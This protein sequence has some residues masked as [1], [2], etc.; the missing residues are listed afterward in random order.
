[1]KL[2]IGLGNPGVK[3]KNTRHNLGFL[4]LDYLAQE[5]QTKFTLIKNFKAEIAEFHKNNQKF[6]LVKPLTYMNLSGTTVKKIKNF[7]KITTNNIL[8]ISDDKDMIFGKTR[9]RT[10]GRS[11]G[12]NGLKNIITEIASEEFLRLKVGVGNSENPLFKNSTAF[13]LDSFSEDELITLQSEIIPKTKEFI[14]KW[15]KNEI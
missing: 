8:V 12:H 6:L 1:M 13:V 7:Y 10:K 11:G 5:Y 2:I 14:I 4:V 15:M 9:M 3:Y